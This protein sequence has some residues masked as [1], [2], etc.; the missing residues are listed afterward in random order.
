[1]ADSILGSELPAAV[2]LKKAG[3]WWSDG[4]AQELFW[5]FSWCHN[6]LMMVITSDERWFMVINK[7]Y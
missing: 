1:M 4:G 7:D 5:W 3:R 2:Y 6:G